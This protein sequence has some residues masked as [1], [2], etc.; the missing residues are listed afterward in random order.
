MSE[1][2]EKKE[3]VVPGQIEAIPTAYTYVIEVDGERISTENLDTAVILSQ[4]EKINKKLD[5]K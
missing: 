2:E 4:L 5:K 3:E 1:K